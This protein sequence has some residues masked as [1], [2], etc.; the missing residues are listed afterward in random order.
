[1][2][3]FRTQGVQNS[4]IY[5]NYIVIALLNTCKSTKV[6]HIVYLRKALLYMIW[7]LSVRLIDDF[8]W[9]VVS[10]EVDG[11][12]SSYFDILDLD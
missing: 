7:I 3:H 9:D 11:V 8:K 2:F 4:D 10:S 1:M 5:F 12:T 6:N